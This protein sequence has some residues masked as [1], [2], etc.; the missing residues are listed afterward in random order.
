MA[1]GDGTF[2]IE[3]AGL[4]RSFGTLRALQD[5]EF[6]I[7][8]GAVFGLLGPNGAGKT[9]TVRILNGVLDA[10]AARVLRVLGRDLPSGAAAIRPLIGVQTDTSLYER[11]PARDNLALFGRLFGLGRRECAE[12]AA[13]LLALFGLE[14]RAK[15]RVETFSKG[16][17]QK[18]LIARALVG[19]PEL[20]YLDEPTAG[21][22]PEASHELMTY[23]S[24]VSRGAHTTFFITSH[25][26]D[27]M[28]DVC[29]Q[30][31]ILAGGTIRASGPPARLARDAVATVR[32]RITPAPGAVLD[33][34]TVSGLPGVVSCAAATDG[35]VVAEA[36]SR[37]AVPLIVRRAAALPVDLLGVCEEPPTL[38]EA[39]LAVVGDRAAAV[40]D[41]G[42]RESDG[43]APRP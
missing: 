17:K 39:Y 24:T 8:R 13:D 16:M 4:E 31:A 32:V 23:I 37:D 6:A 38:A 15:E 21:L 14:D 20:V 10:T 35:A 41:D 28:E 7:P 29:S 5:V 26:L 2:A 42:V 25:R 19:R 36:R 12:R 1:E 34:D 22:D 33:T 27:E 11:L 9:T 30:V 18:L 43:E 3:V 40:A